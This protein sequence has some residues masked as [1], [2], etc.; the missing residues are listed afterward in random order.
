[1]VLMVI[2]DAQASF[3]VIEI[4]HH[5]EYLKNSK[6]SNDFLNT[7]L[8]NHILIKNNFAGHSEPS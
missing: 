2:Q 8:D 1:M 6:C 7:K 4:Q 5:L 3:T